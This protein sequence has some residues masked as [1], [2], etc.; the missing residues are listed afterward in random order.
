MSL[1]VSVELLIRR[2]DDSL[3]LPRYA[4]DG[5]AGLDLHAA[6]ACTLPPGGRALI[7]TGIAIAIPFGFAGFVLP[8]S[9]R[10]IRDGLSVVN[11]PGLIDCHYRG[12]VAVI[13]LNTDTTVPIH[14]RHGD[15]IAQ[16]VVQRVE[17]VTLT[18]VLS[19]DET[20]RGEDGFGSTGL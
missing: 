3:P 13:A 19:L 6:I 10:A 5:D 16:L 20:V 7:P 2:L 11:A 12:E 1:P 18:E 8:R 4:H 15:K 9:G 17:R 14:I